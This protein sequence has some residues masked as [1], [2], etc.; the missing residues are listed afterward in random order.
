VIYLLDTDVISEASKPRPNA[1]VVAWLDQGREL[2]LSVMTIGEVRKGIERKRGRDPAG[3]DELDSW[4]ADIVIEFANRTVPVDA[5]AA[6][7]WGRLNAQSDPL[8]LVDSLIAATALVH[9]WTV[10]TRNVRDFERCG[11]PVANPFEWSR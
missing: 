2:Y 5:A 8:P 11:V 7:M 6:D 1:N 4:L 10:A 3:A 9:G